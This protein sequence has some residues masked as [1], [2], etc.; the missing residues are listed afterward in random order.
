MTT[1]SAPYPSNHCKE[2]MA[3]KAR[4]KCPCCERQ[5]TKFRSF[6]RLD[7]FGATANPLA[8]LLS[9]FAGARVWPNRKRLVVGSRN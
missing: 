1:F 6:L 5:F 8:V 3:T 7:L 4:V 2:T 9:H